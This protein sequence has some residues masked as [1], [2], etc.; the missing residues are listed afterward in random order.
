VKWRLDANRTT[1]GAKHSGEFNV[2]R[3][4][5]ATLALALAAMLAAANAE[6]QYGGS[7]GSPGAGQVSGSHL[8]P[9]RNTQD[10][11]AAD[12]PVSL[13]GQVQVNLDRLGEDLR[14]NAAQQKLWDAYATRVIR[15]A[16]DVSRARFAAREPQAENMTAPQLFDRA[17]E[18]A[19][20]RLTAVEEIVEA[21][22]ALY[23]RLSTEQQ[24]I[25]DRR[26]AAVAMA[27]ASGMPP[28]AA[29][30]DDGTPPGA[31]SR[32]P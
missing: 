30:P 25:A 29:R 16:D 4:A 13:A 18:I 27:L 8:P 20:N 22:R 19:Q 2:I 11:R 12:G 28:G 26:L 1:V 21:G 7:R 14:I 17:T 9:S 31:K 15:L 6:A 24:R 32:A 10:P 3:I 5:S 23:A